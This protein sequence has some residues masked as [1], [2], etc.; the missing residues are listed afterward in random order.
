MVSIDANVDVDAIAGEFSGSGV[1]DVDIGGGVDPGDITVNVG[2][3]G[4]AGGSSGGG[5][6]TSVTEDIE[7]VQD[8]DGGS[9]GGGGQ[10]VDVGTGG[11]GRAGDVSSEDVEQA[12]EAGREQAI[13]RAQGLETADPGEVFK[14]SAPGQ[15]ARAT[16]QSARDLETQIVQDNPSLTRDDVRITLGPGGLE[17]EFTFTGVEATTPDISLPSGGFES[18]R[19]G[20]PDPLDD[21]RADVSL[22]AG[23]FESIRGGT[24]S[25][26]TDT[27]SLDIGAGEP[28]SSIDEGGPGGGGMGS[29]V[30]TALPQFKGRAGEAARAGVREGERREQFFQGLETFAEEAATE[31][32]PHVAGVANPQALAARRKREEVFAQRAEEGFER[33]KS[34]RLPTLKQAGA[35]N[36][37]TAELAERAF[38]Q[39]GEAVEEALPLEGVG[40]PVGSSGKTVGQQLESATS[41]IVGDLPGTV[42]GSV[43]QAPV[44]AAADITGDATVRQRELDALEPISV[45]SEVDLST[46]ASELEAD[47]AAMNPGVSAEDITVTGSPSSGFEIDSDADPRARLAAREGVSRGDI[48]FDESGEQAFLTELADEAAPTSTGIPGLGEPVGEGGVTP[49]QLSGSFVETSGRGFKRTG[50]HALANPVETTVLFAAPAAKGAKG[51]GTGVRAGTGPIGRAAGRV[52]APS[53]SRLKVGDLDAVTLETTTTRGKVVESQ[54]RITVGKGVEGRVETGTPRVSLETLGGAEGRISPELSA[55]ET[56]VLAESL[57]RADSPLEATKV[58]AFR[59]VQARTQRSPLKPGEVE[60]FVG[61]VLEAQ[62]VPRS[63]ARDIVDVMSAE[64]AKLY[65]SLAQEAAARSIGEPGIGRTPRDIDVGE[66]SSKP[67]F[68]QRVTEAINQRAG[69]EVVTI[70]GGT[71]T[72]RA[73]GEKLFDIHEAGAESPSSGSLRAAR[74]PFAVRAEPSVRTSEGIETTTLSQQTAQK[75]AGAM[76]T[77]TVEP[78]TVGPISGRIRPT[79]AGRVKD[80]PD[81]FVGEKANIEALRLAGRTREAAEAE[82]SLTRFIESF[83]EEVATRARSELELARAGERSAPRTELFDFADAGAESPSPFAASAG[84]GSTTPGL[85][86]SPIASARPS[87]GPR[88]A[89][90]SS[91]TPAGSVSVGVSRPSPGGR[92]ADSPISSPVSD[93]PSFNPVSSTAGFPESPSIGPSSDAPT[94]SSPGAPSPPSGVDIPGSGPSGPSSPDIP[95]PGSPSPDPPS[96]DPI[97]SPPET[98]GPPG[99]SRTPP[100][101]LVDIDPERRG[102]FGFDVIDEFAKTFSEAVISEREFLKAEQ[103]P[104]LGGGSRTVIDPGGRPRL[105]SVTGDVEAASS[106][107]LRELQSTPRTRGPDPDPV[108]TDLPAD[109]DPLEFLDDPSAPNTL[110]EDTT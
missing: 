47:I 33:L 83:G 95:S 41:I 88:S 73:T 61:D 69:E 96:S 102:R 108:R 49:G 12:A 89:V 76:E 78:G 60:P 6:A 106:T 21:N 58:E 77:I 51:F 39:F 45:P 20:T 14:E 65:G 103:D 71:P 101:Q 64:G 57:A 54:P 74:D 56:R 110:M 28:I 17:P 68:A 59:E 5:I 9:G 105:S 27:V 35:L 18:I 40:P 70:E 25:G 22:P 99:K 63:A 98:P 1:G 92:A 94:T 62:G 34:G 107:Q 81:F 32:T 97:P 31:P 48:A 100:P 24:P 50:E 38:L 79:H 23:G 13:D 16:G 36:F 87:G 93:I 37:Q 90:P 67:E 42:I 7:D 80:I 53:V 52:P 55:A 30:P 66:V 43:G 29:A 104:S 75:G 4:G 84:I 46:T 91:S 8:T 19:G 15:Q 82:A 26:S 11:G 72:S 85:S 10:D 109:P 44:T 3:S 86:A 2:D